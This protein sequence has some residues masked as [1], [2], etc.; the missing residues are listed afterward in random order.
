MAWLEMP[1]L[2]AD[3]THD[4]TG[5]IARMEWIDGL[6]ADYGLL[7]LF[8]LSFVASTLIPL[9]S[10]LVLALMISRGTP[11]WPAILVATAGNTLGS[12]TSYWIGRQGTS[13]LRRRAAEPSPR[14]DRAEALYRRW[15]WISLLFAWL[16]IVGDPLCVVAG[17]FRHALPWFVIAVTAG[18]L[19]RYI[20][21]ALAIP[22]TT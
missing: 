4:Q 3:D 20:A 22:T 13:I 10:E 19:A 9:S 6:L 17:V 15:G 1:G 12:C 11:F 5:A 7:A 2:G 16:P 18:K 14:F 21:V 8:A